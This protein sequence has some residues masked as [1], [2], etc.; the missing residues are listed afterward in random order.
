MGKRSLL[1]VSGFF[2]FLLF[3]LFSYFVHKDLFTRFDFNSTV[4]LQDN[5]SPRFVEL[6]SLFSEIGKFEISFAVLIVVLLFTRKIIG[7]IVALGLFVGFHLIELYGKF[8]I[9]HPPPPQFMLKTKHLFDFPQFYVRTESSYPSGHSGRTLFLSTILIMLVLQNKSIH[10]G[11]KIV[12]VCLIVIYDA[13]MLVSRVYLGEHWATDV[14]GGA[15]LGASFG[16]LTGIF[17]TGKGKW[18]DFKLFPKF[19]VEIKKV[20]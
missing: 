3:I 9:N 2:L 11:I 20:E 19:K 18:K 1:F 16:L 7:G 5:I 13:I 8:Y 4:R 12:L 10:K 17:L 6:F 14:I 15:L